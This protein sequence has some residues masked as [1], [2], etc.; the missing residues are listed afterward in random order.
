MGSLWCFYRLATDL[1]SPSKHRWLIFVFPFVLT[2]DGSPVRARAQFYESRKRGSSTCRRHREPCKICVVAILICINIP[3]FYCGGA[4]LASQACMLN[5]V[6][7]QRSRDVTND[8]ACCR[9]ARSCLAFSSKPRGCLELAQVSK[10]PIGL[11]SLH[12][13]VPH[14]WSVSAQ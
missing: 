1:D 9:C 8:E 13:N 4:V 6:S 12:K 7:M 3:H 10:V 5:V 14:S 11:R 2:Q